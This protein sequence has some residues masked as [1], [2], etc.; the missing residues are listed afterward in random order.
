MTDADDRLKALF[1]Q[2]EP[3]ARDP[4]FSTAVMEQIAR[5]R[6]VEEVGLLSGATLIGAVVLWLLWPAVTPI[7]APLGQS[8]MP[9]MASLTVAAAA[10]FFLDGRVTAAAILKHD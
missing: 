7:L 3:P 9:V 4:V 1:A 2:D 5:R 6:F 10:V 8:L